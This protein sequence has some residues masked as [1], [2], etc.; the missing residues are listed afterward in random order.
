VRSPGLE[1]S[2]F[3]TLWRLDPAVAYLNHGSFGATPAAVLERQAALRLELEREP[4]DF[5]A[6]QLPGRLA[7]AREALAAFVGADPDDLA[8][9]SN[10][11]S[12]V[13]A[14]LRSL[15]FSPGDELLT[16]DHAY[17][18]CRKA[19][20]FA[21]ARSGARVVVVRVPFPLR[22][23]AEIVDAVLGAASQ[24]TR[25]ALLDHVSSPTG[26]VFPMERLVR[27]LA[28]RGIDTVVDGAHALGMLPL[29]LGTLGAA[30]YT[31]NAHKWLC[32]PKGS[33]FLFVRRDRRAAVQPLVISHGYDPDLPDRGF[34][35]AFDWCGTGDPTAWLAVPECLSHLGSL[36][37]GGW[38]EL[39]A[40]NRSLALEARRIL[41]E[42]LGVPP[43]SPESM[44]GALAALPMPRAAAG[45]AADR[46]D[47]EQLAAWTRERGIEAWFYPWPAPGGKVVRV[48]AQLYNS[49]AQYRALATLLKEAI[50]AA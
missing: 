16:T 13:N 15:P 44:V 43:P 19:L 29:S 10:A 5:L 34:R 39:M 36:L 9:V 25:L 7:A 12:G 8:F 35:A 17:A 33:A 32:A 37:P 48:S 40:R 20:D 41:C 11:T 45:S 2:T 38:P 49:E 27:E 6:R 22:G 50:G 47:H 42:A 1:G 30:Y 18:A 21:A 3:A 4:V 46:L 23:E 14:V 26:L 31:A 24:R 28:A